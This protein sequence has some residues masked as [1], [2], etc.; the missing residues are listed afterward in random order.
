MNTLPQVRPAPIAENSRISP[1]F[2]LPDALR[3]LKASGIEA[4][5]QLA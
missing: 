5:E 4:A 2:I 1:F 3:V